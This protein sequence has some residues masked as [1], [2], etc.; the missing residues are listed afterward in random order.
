[1]DLNFEDK[2]EAAG[3]INIS[4]GNVEGVIEAIGELCWLS[5][6]NEEKVPMHLYYLSRGTKECL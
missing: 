1:M 4:F 5:N 6:V 3:A 2:T